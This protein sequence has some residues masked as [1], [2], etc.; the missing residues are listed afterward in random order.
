MTRRRSAL[1]VGSVALLALVAGVT[2]QTQLRRPEPR[3]T[4]VGPRVV[5]NQT[6]QPLA[7]YGNH[8]R[9]GMKLRLGP[10]F[11][12]TVQVTV[13]DEGHAYARLPADLTLPSETAQVTAALSV[14]GQRER[15]E[16][17]LTVVNDAAF[18]DWTQL[19]RAGDVLR[20]ASSTT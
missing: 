10:P 18:A 3:L 6:A 11:D 12:R 16:V 8:L 20:A 19:V 14:E 7:L 5:S 9:R 1:L 2:W 13:V 17:G 15:S 4:D